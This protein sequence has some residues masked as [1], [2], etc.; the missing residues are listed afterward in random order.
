MKITFD[1]KSGAGFHNESLAKM[2]VQTMIDRAKAEFG[3]K[4]VVGEEK[5]TYPIGDDGKR[6]F[7]KGAIS[8]D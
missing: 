4:E 7:V 1:G 5:L 6:V 3:L 8:L 2:H